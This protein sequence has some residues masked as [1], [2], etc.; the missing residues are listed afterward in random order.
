MSVRVCRARETDNHVLQFSF[1]VLHKIAYD[2]PGAVGAGDSNTARSFSSSFATLLPC[3]SVGVEDL[4]AEE[5]QYSLENISLKHLSEGRFP[6]AGQDTSPEIVPQLSEEEFFSR[7]KEVSFLG[8]M[9]EAARRYHQLVD[10]FLQEA[11]DSPT[12]TLSPDSSNSPHINTRSENTNRDIVEEDND[13]NAGLLSPSYSTDDESIEDGINNRDEN[14]PK[15]QTSGE[16]QSGT[17]GG[18]FISA[19]QTVG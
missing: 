5:Q 17:T 10:D 14:R 4:T 12:R 3:F 8:V 19:H 15:K 9:K 2:G 16:S 18:F 13:G 11:S 1:S 6:V 7:T